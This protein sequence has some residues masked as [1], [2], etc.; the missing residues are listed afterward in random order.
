MTGYQ[1]SQLQRLLLVQA[2]ITVRSIVQAQILIH[3]TFASTSAFCYRITGKF[4]VHTSKIRA[5]LLVDLQ[6]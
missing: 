1:E 3:Q 6:G 5:M 2:R 4:E